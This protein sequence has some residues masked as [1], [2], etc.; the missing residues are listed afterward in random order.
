MEE[1][2]QKWVQVREPYKK[3]HIDGYED[4]NHANAGSSGTEEGLTFTVPMSMVQ[5]SP[6]LFFGTREEIHDEVAAEFEAIS[7]KDENGR[8]TGGFICASG[9]E[10]PPNGNLNNAAHMIDAAKI[11]CNYK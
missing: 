1:M 10:Y 11:Y 7:C 8:D 9:C 5:P 4:D 6:L 3:W 2:R